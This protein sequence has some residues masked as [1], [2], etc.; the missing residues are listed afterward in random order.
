MGSLLILVAGL[1]HFAHA[2]NVEN[3]SFIDGRFHDRL[4][5]Y[6]LRYDKVRMLQEVIKNIFHQGCCMAERDSIPTLGPDPGNTG[7]VEVES[8]VKA[9]NLSQLLSLRKED[10][11]FAFD[12]CEV[13]R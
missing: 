3:H 10:S 2:M 9:A 6:G 4:Y 1:P 7:G 8:S 5:E 11:F 12:S 13:E